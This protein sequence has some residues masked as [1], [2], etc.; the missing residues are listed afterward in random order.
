MV[1]YHSIEWFHFI[2]WC[3][4]NCPLESISYHFSHYASVEPY[5]FRGSLI[6]DGS[7]RTELI[8]FP[9]TGWFSK[10]HKRKNNELK[11][12][13]YYSAGVYLDFFPCSKEVSLLY[14]QFLGNCNNFLGL[15][16]EKLSQLPYSLGFQFVRIGRLAFVIDNI[17]SFNVC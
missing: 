7:V 4:H 10:R 15:Y 9:I 11:K 8:A 5:F 2:I 17:V 1:Q 3:S 13:S 12:F 6:V 16:S 14:K